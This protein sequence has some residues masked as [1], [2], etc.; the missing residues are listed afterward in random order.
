MTQSFFF[1]ES[2]LKIRVAT[3]LV[4]ITLLVNG[5][6]TETAPRLARGQA[7]SPAASRTT[8]S[9][10]SSLMPT[11]TALGAVLEAETAVSLAPIPTPMTIEELPTITR[12]SPFSQNDDQDAPTLGS[13]ATLEPL[14]TPTFAAYGITQT[15]G[16]SAQGRP[17]ITHQFGFGSDKLVLVGGIHGGYEWNTIVLA[18]GLIDYFTENPQHIPNNVTLYIIP[19][20]NPDGQFVTT[21]IEGKITAVDVK[22]NAASSRFNGNGVDLNRN[23]ECNWQET[24]V[25]GQREVDAGKRPFSEPETQAL[26]RF[27][28][29]QNVNT[30]IFWH[31][32]A[33]GVYAGGCDIVYQPSLELTTLFGEAASYPIYEQFTHYPITGDASDWLALQGIPSFTVEL[34]TR[35][36]LDWD[37]NLAGII[38]MLDHFR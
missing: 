8:S 29:G 36:G 2:G 4:I 11:A 18:Y 24:A 22:V 16:F 9:A 33:N 23:W 34:K 14:P 3:M 6:V 5:C 35:N 10:L 13:W 31:S 25:W 32:K 37:Q 38:A 19:S 30:V 27:F 17:L 1:G 12:P 20:A 28:L 21:R 7:V 15:I 26:R